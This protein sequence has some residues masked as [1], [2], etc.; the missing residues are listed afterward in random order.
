MKTKQIVSYVLTALVGMV[1]AALLIVFI[2]SV[3]FTA[4]DSDYPVFEC[5]I[6]TESWRLFTFP[7][8][9]FPA[10]IRFATEYDVYSADSGVIRAILRNVAEA[11]QGY[12]IGAGRHFFIVKEVDDN[13]RIVPFADKGF[14]DI[15]FTMFSGTS[16]SFS[17]TMEDLHHGRLP[18][19]LYRIVKFVGLGTYDITG[20]IPWYLYNTP[21]WRGYVWAEFSV[22]A[23]T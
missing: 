11:N 18:I 14:P 20:E 7:N 3:T 13:W 12:S 17:F 19:G 4:C 9:Y 8:E 5:D 2:V 1:L 23:Y 21:H 22:A 16:S 15:A 6:D 10:E